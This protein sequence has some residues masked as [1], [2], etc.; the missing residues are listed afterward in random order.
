MSTTPFSLPGYLA[1]IKFTD[2]TSSPNLS[3]LNALMKS[4]LTSI[5]FENISVACGESISID[6]DAVYTKMVTNKRGGYCFEQSILFTAALEGL[7]Y[8]VAPLLCRVRWGKPADLITAYTHMCLRVT[9]PDSNENYLVDV[10]FAGTNSISAVS[11]DASGSQELE[12]GCFKV[13]E[14]SG[15]QFLSVQDRANAD[16]WRDLYCWS[17]GGCEAPDLEQ[18]NWFSCSYPGARFMN[19]F[20]VAIVA[21]DSKK[22][23]LNNE[24]VVRSTDGGIKETTTITDVEHLKEILKEHFTLEIKHV[25]GEIIKR[26]LE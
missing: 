25:E 16:E 4:H 21:G 12:D 17:L 24:F 5:P 8:T 2:D 20:F 15:Y 13:T 1:H 10:G 9:L 3:T 23:V 14:R 11:L 26:Y 19:Q 7:G 18:S 22:H 6:R